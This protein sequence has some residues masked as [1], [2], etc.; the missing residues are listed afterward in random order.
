MN[1]PLD[2]G[3]SLSDPAFWAQP[4]DE[5][6]AGF[7]WLRHEAPVS[8]HPPAEGGLR[9]APPG[10]GDQG[11]WAVVRHKDV[12]AVSRDPETFCSRRG[13]ALEPIPE[14][15]AEAIGSLVAM[16]PPRH[17]QFRKLI[18]SAFT[19]RQVARTEEQVRRQ[20]RVIV[21][22]F[23]TGGD[24]DFVEAVARRLP[25]WT[26]SEMMGVPESQRERVADVANTMTAWNDPEY[27]G[28]RH[29]FDVFMNCFAELTGVAMELAEFRRRQPTDDLMTG[30]VHAEVDGQRLTNE[31][32]AALVVLLSV[33]GNDTSRNAISHGIKAF[34]DNPDQRAFVLEDFAGRIRPA[35][36]EIVRLA[37]PV[38]HFRRTATRAVVLRGQPI[39]AGDWVVVFY[40]AANRDAAVFSDPCRFNAARAPNPH[41]GFGGGGPHFCLGASLARTQLR[42]IF[43]ELLHRVPDLEVGAP[44][45]LVSN[46]INGIKRLP[47]RFR[48]AG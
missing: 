26:I 25:T 1:R 18:S 2:V 24:C 37:S 47:C 35:V 9:L 43:D 11:Y 34:C 21:D 38:I 4:P 22:D 8:W 10:P 36:E 30:L 7:V 6:E 45:Y 32:L 27:T 5:R 31:E 40:P 12:V 16:D 44:D 19:P 14:Q 17:T 20:A 3:L 29:P 39:D 28:D 48:A 23:L 33:A 13:V 15:L 42:A 41:L 46:F